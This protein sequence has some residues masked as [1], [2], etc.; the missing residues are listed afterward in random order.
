[1]LHYYHGTDQYRLTQAARQVVHDIKTK[2]PIRMA[3]LDMSD[4]HHRDEL[5]R[6]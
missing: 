5:E 3:T 2:G 1:M 4:E 6:H